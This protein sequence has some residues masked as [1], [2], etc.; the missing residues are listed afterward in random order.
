M[1]SV[2]RFHVS[3]YP[4]TLELSLP[5]ICELRD[6]V[7]HFIGGMKFLLLPLHDTI[8]IHSIN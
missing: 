2:H 4:H 5:L 7:L 3:L 8:L 1:D 6:M